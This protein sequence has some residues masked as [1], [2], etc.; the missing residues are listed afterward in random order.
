MRKTLLVAFGLSTLISVNSFAEV[1]LVMETSVGNIELKLDDER[2]P[3][4][5]ANFVDYAK[6]G[7]FD[8]LIFHRVI[9]NFMI[10]GGGMDAD[11]RERQTRAPIRNESDNGLANVRGAIAMARTN[12]PNSATSQFF[13]NTRD[14]PSLNAGGPYGGYAVFGQVHKGME[15][16][17][18]ISG[19]KTGSRGYHRDVPVEPIVIKTVKLVD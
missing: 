16:V 12:D 19:V 11:M 13:I 5:V 10:Q 15:V 3:I 8:G 17:D 6:S 9:P 7:Y 2:A 18:R 1:N 4:T 14:N